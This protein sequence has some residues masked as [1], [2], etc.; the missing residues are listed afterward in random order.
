MLRIE[1]YNS[2]DA[3]R[4]ILEGRLTGDDA[5]HARLLITRYPTDAKLVVDLTEVV[6]IDGLGEEVLAFFGR[7]GA[8]FVAPTSYTL[9]IC[10]RLHLPLVRTAGS[11]ANTLGASTTNRRRSCPH[12]SE[13]QKK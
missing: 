2:A 3:V 4:L 6:F 5:E 10:E 11:H 1:I 9:D 7:L 8:E 12:A 13:P